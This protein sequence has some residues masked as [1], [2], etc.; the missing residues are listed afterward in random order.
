MPL[1]SDPEEPGAAA[2]ASGAAG[3]PV[4]AATAGAGGGEMVRGSVKLDLGGVGMTAEV[5][6][7][8]GAVRVRELLPVLRGFSE[9]IVGVAVEKAEKGGRKVSCKAGCG[10]CCRQL[11][12]ISEAEA[13]LLAE[14][15]AGM[16]EPRRGEVL[17]RFA[18][19]REKLKEAGLLE[20]VAHLPPAGSQ[21]KK[22]LGL[23]YFREG[24]ACPFLEEE[25]CS[26]YADRP[27]ICREYLVTNHAKFCAAERGGDRDGG[28]AGGDVGGVDE[29]VGF[30]GAGGV[31]AG[32]GMGGG[33]CGGGGGRDGA[34]GADGGVKAGGAG[35]EKIGD[36]VRW[37]FELRVQ[38]SEFVN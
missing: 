31:G 26:I 12:P 18:A 28:G 1:S 9:A 20:D 10:A 4:Q 3:A 8:K 17:G 35:G 36:G 13:H 16:A 15:V 32:V 7:P 23:A 30:G 11:V 37:S 22:E 27:L 33:A 2:G 24:I 21:E 6:V 14:L 34:G 5:V 38:S 29:G 25:S 19:A